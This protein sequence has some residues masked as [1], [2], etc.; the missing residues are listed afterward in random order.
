[1]ATGPASS[2][3]NSDDGILL[4]SICKITSGIV[5]LSLG[6]VTEWCFCCLLFVFVVCSYKTLIFIGFLPVVFLGSPGNDGM[7]WKT[8][9][10]VSD[11]LI[12][13]CCRLLGKSYRR[14]PCFF[15]SLL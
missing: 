7:W 5:F 6:N 11:Q 10:S 8:Q 1:M 15:L 13:L 9:G 14:C 12:A 2:P 4:S 3:A